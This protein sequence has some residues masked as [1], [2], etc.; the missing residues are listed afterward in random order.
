MRRTDVLLISEV[1]VGFP[2]ICCFFSLN[3]SELIVEA[4]LGVAMFYMLSPDHPF[5]SLI[6]GTAAFVIS[7]GRV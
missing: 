4:R 7:I 2:F 5:C 6:F 1:R 3:P